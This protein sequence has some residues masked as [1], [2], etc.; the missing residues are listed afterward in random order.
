MLNAGAALQCAPIAGASLNQESGSR[1]V[2]AAT[3]AGASPTSAAAL[4]SDKLSACSEECSAGPQDGCGWVGLVEVAHGPCCS[5]DHAPS[6]GAVT[7]AWIY[8]KKVVVHYENPRNVGSLGK[9]SKNVGTGPSR[10]G[11][12]ARALAYRLKDT[13]KDLYLSP[14]KLHCSMLAEGVITAAQADYKLKQ[15]PKKREAKKRA[16]GK[17]SNRI[18]QLLA[19]LPFVHPISAVTNWWS[20]DHW[21]FMRSER[22]ATVGLRKPLEQGLPISG[23]LMAHEVR[24]MSFQKT[25]QTKPGLRGKPWS[26]PWSPVCQQPRSCRCCSHALMVRSDWGWRQQQV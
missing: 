4:R 16:L 10:F 11:S 19:H 14:V 26:R 3:V 21:W 15:D 23:T 1:L 24:N 12:V 6:P 22:L 20:T 9:T 7:Q 2:S 25:F 13:S 18:L 8:H 5:G 17:A